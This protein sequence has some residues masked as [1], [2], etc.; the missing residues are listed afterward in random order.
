[1]PGVLVVLEPEAAR[2]A[3]AEWAAAGAARYRSL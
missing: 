1:M 3:V 2:T